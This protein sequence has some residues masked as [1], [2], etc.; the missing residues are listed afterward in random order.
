VSAAPGQ[1][2][3]DAESVEIET[4]SENWNVYVLEDGTEVRLKTVL[5]QVWRVLDEYD[6]DGNPQYVFKTTSLP[7][8]RASET[9]RKKVQ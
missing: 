1:P 5:L 2:P 7:V 8:V 6:Q 4:S 3:K 9:V